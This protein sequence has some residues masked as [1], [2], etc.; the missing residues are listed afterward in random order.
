MIEFE[1]EAEVRK[2]NIREEFD[3]QKIELAIAQNIDR[4]DMVNIFSPTQ[5]LVEHFTRHGYFYRPNKVTYK[6][7]VPF[8]ESEYISKL[9]KNKRKTIKKA[10]KRC[11]E[12]GISILK[13]P[14]LSEVSYR[15]WLDVYTENING[16]KRGIIRTGLERYYRSKD[17]MAGIFA[18]KDNHIIGGIILRRKHL[19]SG[20]RKISFSF[21]SSRKEYFKKGVNE[22]LNLKAVLFARELGYDHLERGM[23]SNLYGHYL[24]PGLYLFKKSFGFRITPKNRFGEVLTTITNYAPF[25]D[26][27]FFVSHNKEKPEGNLILK[28]D[29]DSTRIAEFVSKYLER[30]NVYKVEDNTIRKVDEIIIPRGV[31][32]WQREKPQ[33]QKHPL[34]E[35]S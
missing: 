8:S 35:Y 31:M 6:M 2:L 20:L 4:A 19:R 28:N 22:L 12:C 33:Y 25:Q 26:I 18:V 29:I 14:Q 10:V 7:D 24:S 34:Q 3:I 11:R 16:K 15:G 17:M 5:G 9:K 23:D 21:A 27:I 1:T 32:I 13:E 30:L